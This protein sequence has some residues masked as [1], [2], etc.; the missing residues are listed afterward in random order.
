MIFARI[1]SLI[2]IIKIDKN[3]ECSK[4]LSHKDVGDVS[5]QAECLIYLKIV[6][7]SPLKKKIVSILCCQKVSRMIQIRNTVC[8]KNIWFGREWLPLCICS[9][10]A[11][12]QTVVRCQTMS[13]QTCAALIFDINHFPSVI[14]LDQEVFCTNKYFRAG[15]AAKEAFL[16]VWKSTP[17][18]I[19]VVYFW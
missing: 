4:L 13:V 17:N 5:L 8:K 6:T 12:S 15:P 14:D 11:S 2:I 10:N 7:T 9:Q 3:V 19:V 16:E 1:L 18:T